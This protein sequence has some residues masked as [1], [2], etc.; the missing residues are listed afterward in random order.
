MDGYIVTGLVVA[1]ALILFYKPIAA[2]IGSI[3]RA[4]K[5]G[6]SFERQQEIGEIKPPILTFVEL[7]K[8][9]IS[10]ST[11]AREKAVQNQLQTFGLKSV[12]EKISFLSRALA[13]TRVTLEFNNI[14]YTI[15]GSQITLLVR[16]S[17]THQSIPDNHVKDIFNQAQLSFPELHK[18]KTFEEWLNYLKNNDLIS[19]NKDRLN[20]SQYGSDFLK[21][22]IDARLAYNR[23]G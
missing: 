8:E 17:G 3:S 19:I 13:T 10:A 23:Y 12:E 9:P 2:K 16:L 5:D 7:M 6:V 15:F 1:F 21:H 22:L 11:L 14:A 4:G 20:I 18:E